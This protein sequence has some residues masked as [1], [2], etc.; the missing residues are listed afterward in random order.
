MGRLQA[1]LSAQG[2]GGRQPGSRRV[3]AHLV[4][5]A[6]HN[7]L[8]PMA[9]AELVAQL[10]PPGVADQHLQQSRGA[11]GIS[12]G[13][14]SRVMLPT[15]AGWK[16]ITTYR[17]RGG[18]AAASEMCLQ[19]AGD[20]V[21]LQMW[22]R[23]RCGRAGNAVPGPG[24][25]NLQGKQ[26][27]KLVRPGA[28]SCSL[29][30]HAHSCGSLEAP[31]LPCD[32]PAHQSASAGPTCGQPN[33]ETPTSLHATPAPMLTKDLFSQQTPAHPPLEPNRG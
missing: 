29:Q 14:S 32:P 31:S 12:C 15:Q 3:P 26:S 8:L 5:D 11:G 28:W 18:N 6:A 7:T 2:Q 27:S 19:A 9:T 13:A 23:G 16:H 10:R 17:Q 1:A 21:Q 30:Q 25:Q 24:Q 22:C 4:H 33:R 20:A